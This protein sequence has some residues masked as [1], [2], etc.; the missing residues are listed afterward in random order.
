M[1]DAVTDETTAKPG[2]GD[3]IEIFYAPSAVFARRRGGQFGLPYLALLVVGVVLFFATRNLMQPVIDAE[4]SRS[5]AQAAARGNMTPDAMAK[6]E[7]FGK[8]FASVGLIAFW[9]IAPFVIGLFVWVAGKI[10]KVPAIGGV[11]I[12]IAVF[13]MFPR[14]VGS[15]V[16]AVLAA[17]L[18]DTA[19][20]SAASVSLSPARFVDVAHHPGVAA[21]L[22]RFDLFILWGVVLIAI[23]ARVA[24]RAT[25]GQAWATAIGAWV[26]ASLPALWA[27]IRS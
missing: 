6:A 19:V 9:V 14:L 10:A 17:V 13:S 18:P 20:T 23:G 12:M 21:L 2:A 27:L 8:A 24:G 26:I 7:S 11:A 3:L 25:K 1:T 5:M 4:I 16:A 15:V 22:G